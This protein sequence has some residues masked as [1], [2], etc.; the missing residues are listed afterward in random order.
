[1][2]SDPQPSNQADQD[3][4]P[5]PPSREEL[6]AELLDIPDEPQAP[7]SAPEPT[8]FDSLLEKAVRYVRAKRGGDLMAIILVGS[9]ARRALTPHSD[10]DLIAVVKGQ[11]E[12]EDTVRIADR[13]VEVRYRAQKNME[14]DLAHNPRLPP[15]LRRGRI[16]FELEAAGTRLVDKANQRFRQGPP[17]AS[18]H[19][20][21]R[22]K[23][24]CH[25]WLGKAE[26]LA[27][28]Q[29]AAQYLLAIFF[30]E[31]IEA[32]FR[33]RGFW[34]TAPADT[35]RFVSTRDK[36]VGEAA[37]QFLTAG[38][39]PDRIA[40]GRRLFGAIFQDVPNPQRVD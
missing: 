10:L 23:A 17:P 37:E 9:G 3:T 34:L 22:L 36:M 6:Q 7:P 39:L 35:L 24:T 27:Q 26:D 4:A 18:I 13:T 28:N 21:I 30:E 40:A 15:L 1:M 11:D 31:A 12:G 2:T 16:L 38:S 25:H 29:A 20:K 33:L 8:G 19:E 32:F 5:I 14:Q